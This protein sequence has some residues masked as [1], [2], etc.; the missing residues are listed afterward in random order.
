MK[1][2]ESA[3][4]PEVLGRRAAAAMQFLAGRIVPSGGKLAPGSGKYARVVTS[5]ASAFTIDDD[6]DDKMTMCAQNT[7]LCQ[8]PPGQRGAR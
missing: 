1:P 4:T 6:D 2:P 7:Q 3:H 5:D 8:Q